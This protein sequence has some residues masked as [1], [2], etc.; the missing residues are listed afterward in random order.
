[1]RLLWLLP[2]ADSVTE[3]MSSHNVTVLRLGVLRIKPGFRSYSIP[4][5]I[6]RTIISAGHKT[7][8]Y[9]NH[10]QQTF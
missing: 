6:G 7:A 3:G 1:M 2:I 4:L 10:A 8:T 5:P 9:K